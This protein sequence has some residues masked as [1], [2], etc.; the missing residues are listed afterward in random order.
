MINTKLY[1]LI[2][3]GLAMLL[4][5][6]LYGWRSAARHTTPTLTSLTC[7]IKEANCIADCPEGDEACRSRCERNC[8]AGSTEGP[9]DHCLWS[10]S[11]HECML[12]KCPPGDKCSCSGSSHPDQASCYSSCLASN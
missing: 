7:A 3:A 1:K 12:C 10:E 11:A 4:A 5:L 6:T 2:V 9:D 8:P